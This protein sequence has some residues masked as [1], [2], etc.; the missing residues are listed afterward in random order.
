MFFTGNKSLS[1]LFVSHFVRY[2]TICD[3]NMKGRITQSLITDEEHLTTCL[4][5]PRS[6]YILNL[7]YV[8]KEI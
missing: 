7:G 2:E 6:D 3:D 8:L 4:T 1:N 5:V